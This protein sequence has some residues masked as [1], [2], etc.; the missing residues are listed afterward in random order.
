MK[1]LDVQ[2]IALRMDEGLTIPECARRV[3]LPFSTVQSRVIRLMKKGLLPSR[4]RTDAQIELPHVPPSASLPKERR[5]QETDHGQAA[6]VA[7]TVHEPVRTLADLVTVCEIDTETWDVV[8]WTANTWE[9]SARNDAGELV[10]KTLYQVKARLK[11]RA[12]PTTEATLEALADGVIAARGPMRVA[13]PA[14]RRS[15]APVAQVVVIADPHF[16]KLCWSKGT[17]GADYDVDIAYT[18]LVEGA[19]SLIRSSGRVEKRYL[20][21][22]GDFFHFDTLGGTTTGG[23]VVDR[24]SRV[25][26][27]LDVGAD[28]LARIVRG[29]ARSAETELVIVPGNHDE[30]LSAALQRIM[31]AEFRRTDGVAIDD[32]HTRRKARLYGRNLLGFNHGDK[33]KKDLCSA[34]AIDNAVWWGQSVYRE[35]HTGHLHSEGERYEGTLTHAG[36][37][38]RTHRS[39]TPPDQWHA[40]EGYIGSPRGMS[41]WLYDRRGGLTGMHMYSPDVERAA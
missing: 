7:T 9:A 1:A 11:R 15:R 34:L 25:P 12:G 18:T 8:E 14:I 20:V 24:D 17:G 10:P 36:V 33:K 27:I 13:A 40:D 6:S 3:G 30:V 23:T 22:L 38:L 21:S 4:R 19:A 28:A 41:A 31:V 37:T 32:T 26:K 35:I 5:W 29:S 2:L 16:G 39:L